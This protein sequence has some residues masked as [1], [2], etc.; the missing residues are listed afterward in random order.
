MKIFEFELYNNYLNETTYVSVLANSEEEALGLLKQDSIFQYNIKNP[1][2]N[3]QGL[4]NIRELD[5]PKV[6]W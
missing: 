1:D 6:L 3:F 5:K 2:I 4:F